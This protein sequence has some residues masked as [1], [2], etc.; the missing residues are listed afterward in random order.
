MC[1]KPDMWAYSSNPQQVGCI[2]VNGCL[3]TNCKMLLPAK[4]SEKQM[5]LSAYLQFIMLTLPAG[6]GE[7]D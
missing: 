6:V 1:Q 7:Y 5:V 2:S 4:T 3:D